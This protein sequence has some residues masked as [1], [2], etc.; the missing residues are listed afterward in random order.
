MDMLMLL[1]AAVTTI[2]LIVPLPSYAAEV[3]GNCDDAKTRVVRFLK[4]AHTGKSMSEEKW[5]TE[6]ARRAPVFAGFGGLNAL[7]KQSTARAKKYGGLGPI[8]VRSTNRVG[9]A[10]EVSAEV[11][12]LTNHKDPTNPAVAANEDM[13]WTFQMSIQRGLWKIAS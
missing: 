13:V 9:E 11:K 6:E 8:T 2:G 7:V 5:L 10:C 4:D 3:E 12:F 1:I